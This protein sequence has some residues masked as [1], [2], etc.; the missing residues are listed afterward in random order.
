LPAQTPRY[1]SNS[2]IAF[3]DPD[4]YE[5]LELLAAAVESSAS[6]AKYV[7]AVSFEIQAGAVAE[8]ARI[9]AI[10]RMLNGV[11]H[12]PGRKSL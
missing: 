3:A 8:F 12:H 5:L 2:L 7:M 11:A 10:T 4:R 1:K 6:R 9:L